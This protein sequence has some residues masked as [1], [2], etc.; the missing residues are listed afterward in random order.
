M[1]RCSVCD[2]ND[3]YDKTTTTRNGSLQAVDNYWTQQ[4]TKTTPSPNDDSTLY[5][6]VA[7]S[8]HYSYKSTKHCCAH[9]SSCYVQ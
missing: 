4:H 7:K 3:G 6:T 8:L 1:Y 9:Q 2:R 5:N